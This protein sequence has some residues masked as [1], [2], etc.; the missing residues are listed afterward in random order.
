MQNEQAATYFALLKTNVRKHLLPLVLPKKTAEKAL[1]DAANNVSLCLLEAGVEFDEYFQAYKSDA[2]FD[3]TVLLHGGSLFDAVQPRYKILFKLFYEKRSIGFG[4]PNAA[5]GEGELAALCSSPRVKISKTAGSGDLLIDGTKVE[6]KGTGARIASAVLGSD[7]STR[8]FEVSKRFGVQPNAVAGARE[9]VEP[10][11]TSKKK[12]THWDNEFRRIG[13]KN[14]VRFIAEIMSS[15]G[16]EFS[17]DEVQEFFRD[18]EFNRELAHKALLKAFF[19]QGCE[20]GS[21]WDR[22]TCVINGLVYVIENDSEKFNAMVDAG[23]VKIEALYFRM[24]QKFPLSFYY[25]F[26]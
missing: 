11:D 7:F 24:F 25:N 8:C 18:E 14:T 22:L 13:Y 23:V 6:L 26:K 12:I 20:S 19:R 3:P 21:S 9:S 16:V 1:N 10:L 17:E 5:S 4:T 2:I 15:T